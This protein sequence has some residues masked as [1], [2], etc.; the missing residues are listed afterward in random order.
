M[1][2]MLQATMR[3]TLVS[4]AR[5]HNLS[6]IEIAIMIYSTFNLDFFA[7]EELSF[8]LWAGATALDMLVMKY[9]T[10]LFALVLIVSTVLLVNYCS[11]VK[12][13][14][15]LNRKNKNQSFKQHSIV[16]GI[17]AFLVIC[18]SQCTLI[19]FYSLTSATIT[20]KGG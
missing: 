14:K 3:V 15:Y 17:T 7:L 6:F 10:V 2:Q 5:Y 4:G 20:G 9:V 13:R 18:Y 16:Q 19:A 1:L 8:C 12:L 11:C